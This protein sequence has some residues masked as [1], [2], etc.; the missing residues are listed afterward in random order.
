MK[1]NQR[2][3]LAQ[4]ALST[5]M[6]LGMGSAF[7][8]VERGTQ[9]GITSPVQFDTKLKASDRQL[10]AIEGIFTRIET[11]RLPAEKEKLT[12]ELSRPLAAYAK[13]MI[14]GFSEAI[15]Q[16]EI[17]TKSQ[18][19]EGSTAILKPFEDLAAKHEQRLKKLDERAQKISSDIEK[20]EDQPKKSS[21]IAEPAEAAKLAIGWRLLEKISDL[22]ISPAH[23]AIAIPVVTTCSNANP[24]SNPPPTVAQFAACFVATQTAGAL[25]DQAQITFTACWNAAHRHKLKRDGHIHFPALMHTACTA[26]LVARLA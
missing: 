11:A 12:D 16:A 23:A 6:A 25:K 2:R 15:K 14:E 10:G 9:G 19:K 21:S 18:G 4:V 22:F 7:A 17:A 20:V 13:G 24:N 8:Q 3:Q 26:T 1:L 5:L